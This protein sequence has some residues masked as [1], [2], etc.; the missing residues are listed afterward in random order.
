MVTMTDA[1]KLPRQGQAGF[2]MVELI[3]AI[4]ILAVGLLGLAGTTGW[5]VRQTTMSDVVTER[6]MARQAAMES[7]RAQPFDAV[8]DG[9]RTVGRFEITWQV[10][11]SG[12]EFKTVELI[13]T[14][15]GLRSTGDGLP[16]LGSGVADTVTFNLLEIE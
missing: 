16:S 13:T 12:D 14:G 11:D 8:I 10:I 2:T 9:S 6:A 15:R 7:I 1:R 3:V 5:V 4:V